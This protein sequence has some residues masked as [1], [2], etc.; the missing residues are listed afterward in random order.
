LARNAAPADEP[1]TML[2]ALSARR[3]HSR[4]WH[5]CAQEMVTVGGYLRK[6]ATLAVGVGACLAANVR[7]LPE[8]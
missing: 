7:I 4:Q 6:Q 2:D 5:G 1:K 3:G 8:L